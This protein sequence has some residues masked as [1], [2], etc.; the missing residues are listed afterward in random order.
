MSAPPEWLTDFA[1]AL[2]AHLHPTASSAPIGCHYHHS[3]TTW[4]ITL[5]VS[6]REILGGPNDGRLQA[7][8]F[9][10]DLLGICQVFD[11]V[12]S[13]AWQAH[14]QGRW[15]ELG[16]HVAVEGDYRGQ[17]VWLRIPAMAPAQF[18]AER[19][20]NHEGDPQKQV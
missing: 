20:A 15:D 19:S 5:F 18:P 17:R 4:E 8:R 6:R 10:L 13:V 3:G 9:C 1:Q 2:L 16:A 14:R 7:T 11:Q 12:S